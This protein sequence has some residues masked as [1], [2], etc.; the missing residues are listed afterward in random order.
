[1][2]QLES[3]SIFDT[4]GSSSLIKDGGPASSNNHSKFDEHVSSNNM[5]NAGA[6]GGGLIGSNSLNDLK[7]MSANF[8][9][10]LDSSSR[11]SG[12]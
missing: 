7:Q 8:T 10:D 4:I 1:N 5:I 11:S 6:I 2:K 12:G 9:N 3:T